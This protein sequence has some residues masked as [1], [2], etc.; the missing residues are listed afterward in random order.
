MLKNINTRIP[1]D[2]GWFQRKQFHIRIHKKTAS[3]PT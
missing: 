2:I 3:G 1:F